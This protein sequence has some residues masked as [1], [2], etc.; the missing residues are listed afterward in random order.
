MSRRP[1]DKDALEDL[2]KR[3]DALETR[4]R[5]KP[6]LT[7]DDGAGA[8]YR[9]VAELVSSVLAGLGLG[10]LSDQFLTPAPLGILVGV[11]V[12]AAAGIYLVVLTASR[13]SAKAR[14][15]SGPVASVPD[16]PEED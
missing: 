10:W 3:L 9:L 7:G 5:R 6:G 15:R 11:L 2:N 14:A 13:M 16:D 4:T 1:S 12:G 8:G